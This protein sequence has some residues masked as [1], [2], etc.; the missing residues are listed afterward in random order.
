MADDTV[1]ELESWRKKVIRILS[2]R[3]AQTGQ[4][5][6]FQLEVVDIDDSWSEEDLMAITLFS[7]ENA[8]TWLSFDEQD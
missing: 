5:K 4:V 1:Y 3:L 2:P 7:L 8:E 6:D